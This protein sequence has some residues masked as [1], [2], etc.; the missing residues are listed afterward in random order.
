MP[1]TYAWAVPA[2]LTKTAGCGTS[3]TT[4]KVTST[5]VHSG[6]SVSVTVTDASAGTPA[7]TA[8]SSSTL[9]VNKPLAVKPPTSSHSLVDQGQL[10]VESSSVVGGT[11]PYVTYWANEDPANLTYTTIPGSLQTSSSVITQTLFQTDTSTAIG[12]WEFQVFVTD[13]S[14]ALPEMASAINQEGVTVYQQLLAF[15][16][17]SPIQLIGGNSSI[18]TGSTTGG[19]NPANFACQWFSEQPGSPTFLSIA[20]A[21]SCNLYTFVTTPSTAKEHGPLRCG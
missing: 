17:A 14:N 9:N 6:Y 18:L 13:S 11:A 20:G 19:S 21:T 16:S 8:S 4:C 5:T 7:E 12:D 3:D 2:G 1:Y 15:S 10:S